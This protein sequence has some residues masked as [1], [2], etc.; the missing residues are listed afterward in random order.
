M[1]QKLIHKMLKKIRVILAA[2]V[3]VAVTLLFLDFTGAIHHYLG[4]LAKIRFLPAVLA[5]NLVVVIALV[6]L[7]VLFGRVYCSVICP[8]GVFQDGVANLSKKGKK[9]KYSYSPEVKWLRYGVFILFVVA[10]IAG[11]NAFVALLAPYSAWGRIVQNFLAPVWQW[12]NNLFASIAEKH[13][14]YAFYTKEVWLKSLP[15]FIIALVTL[16]AVVILAWK[17]GRTYCNTIC[18]VGTTLSFFSRFAA[19][20]PVID[21]SK[22][23]SCHLCEH[24]C[25][26]ACIDID[27][28]KTIDYSRCVDCFNCIDNCKFGALKYRFAWDTKPEVPSGD[29]SAPADKTR[30]AFMVGSALALGGSALSSVKALAQTEPADE[31]AVKIEGEGGFAD[32]IPKVAPKRTVAIT[33]FGSESVKDFYSHC[34]ACQLCVAVC[35][36]NVLRPSKDLKHLMQPEMS[37]ERGYCRPECVKCSEVCPAGAILKITPEEKTQWKVGTAHI[38]PWLCIVDNGTVEECGNC[39]RHCPT[40]AIQMV[41][42]D[43]DNPRS[44]RIPSV[45]ESK[46]IGCGACENLCPARPV[47]AITVDGYQIH[48]KA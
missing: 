28:G 15:T 27:G 16:V 33:P 19:F 41:R 48:H 13:E 1:T 37:F 7:T 47:S 45:D 24:K 9:G 29:T 23:K 35:P 18:P 38:T 40:G 44:V 6:I 12:G 3:F 39:A 32:I 31:E 36:N 14:S 21:A 46:C 11:V 34:T 4:W 10:L 25:K 30:R 20:R 2:L 5:L 22:C 8:L 43:P 26:A 17:N 42:K